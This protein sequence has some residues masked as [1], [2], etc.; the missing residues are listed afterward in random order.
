MLDLTKRGAWFG[1]PEF[2][3]QIVDLMHEHRRQDRLAQGVYREFGFD[4]H[5]NDRPET[6]ENFKGCAIGCLI[7]S[8]LGIEINRFSGEW[9]GWWREVEREF[10][11]PALVAQTIDRHFESQYFDDAAIFA[12]ASIEAIPVGANLNEVADQLE[13]V[14]WHLGQ[15]NERWNPYR[16]AEQYSCEDCSESIRLQRDHELFLKAL[17]NAPLMTAARALILAG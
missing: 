3:Q 14:H 13:H 16:T 11:I 1:D 5:G 10:N 17:S 12:V 6:L 8:K 7:T 2:K 9:Q 4:E 15:L